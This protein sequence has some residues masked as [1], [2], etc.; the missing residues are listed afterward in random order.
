M[1]DNLVLFTGTSN[2]D[3]V[4]KIARI[5]SKKIKRKI[6]IYEPISHFEDGE[7]GLYIPKLLRRKHVVVIQ[8]TSPPK[9]NDYIMEAV[10]MA[11]AARRASAN[12]ISAVIPYFGYGRQ[13][14]KD[15]PRVSICAAVVADILVEAGFDRILTLDI[16]AEQE[17]GFIKQP[18][19]NLFT[20]YCLVPKIKKENI[21]HL[22]IASPDAGGV[23]RAK[24]YEACLKAD[25]IAI[26]LKN[27]DVNKKDECEV[28]SMVGD[29]KGKNVLIVDDIVGT[30]SSISKA[31]DLF[32]ANG[33]KKVYVAAAHGIFSGDALKKIE[34]FEKVF[35]TDTINHRDEVKKC[36]KIKIVS[37][38]RLLAEA[39]IRIHTGKSISKGLI[40]Y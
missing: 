34:G 6:E 17:Q 14:K 8:S 36:S 1:R 26:V 2:I 28:V 35:V 24:L 37:V 29:V 19:D 27:R 13:D 12:E 30:A 20:S 21:K 31:R 25:G 33:A 7:V 3:L 15:K 4:K 5:I 11:D 9:T 10:F 38:A 18:W 23:R 40:L 16:H 32:I 22:V 39:I